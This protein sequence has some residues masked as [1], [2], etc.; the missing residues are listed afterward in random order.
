[1]IIVHII[2][3][4]SYEN[5]YKF[6]ILN[7]RIKKLHSQEKDFSTFT[8]VGRSILIKSL[9]PDTEYEFRAKVSKSS[10]GYES[11]FSALSR[12]K[13]DPGGLLVLKIC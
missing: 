11:E 5:L 3:V 8:T 4:K 13:T 6:S 9:E 12:F 2:F 1:L 7:F 10:T